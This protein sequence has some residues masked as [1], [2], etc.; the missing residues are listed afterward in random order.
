[1]QNAALKELG[2]DYLYVPLPV[3]PGDLPVAIAGLR[4]LNLAGCNVTI[5]HKEGVFA[6]LD[7]LSPAAKLAGAVNT[8][9]R[10]GD[11]LVGYNTD[12]IGLLTALREDLSFE[13]AGKEVVLL[14]AGG[15]ARGAVS[16]IAQAGVSRI[17]LVNRSRA[18][19][20]ELAHA[21][22]RHF[23]TVPFSVFTPD[24]EELDGV[25]AS[26][27]L[28]I[29]SVPAAGCRELLA[30][31]PLARVPHTALFYDMVYAS[32]PTPLIVVARKLGIGHADGVGMLA[33]Q[34]GEAFFLWTGQRSPAGFMKQILLQAL[35][36]Q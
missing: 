28:V 31:L 2:L 24:A 36:R 9:C 4:A 12:G 16:A 23:S 6:L 29:N 33:A 25:V 30:L 32:D 5:P 13:V 19:G 11:E 1:M 17:T 10:E 7:R 3:V 8:I 35:G 34:G 21:M 15:A 26:A 27:D 14:G 20:E 22:A 18:R